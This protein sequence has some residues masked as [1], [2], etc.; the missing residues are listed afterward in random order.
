M[1]PIKM[2]IFGDVSNTD[3]T[4]FEFPTIT[5]DESPQEMLD[6]MVLVLSRHMSCEAAFKGGYMLNQLLGAASRRTS[7][8]D[9]PIAY[10]GDY[11]GVK[12][13]LVQIAEEFIKYD[14]IASYK[15]KDTVEER[16]SGGIDMYAKN[17]TKIL[18][19]DVGL[20][21]ISYGLKHYDLGFTDVDGFSI[22]RMLADKMISITSRKRFRRTK[23][24]YDFYAITNFFD[25]D[26]QKLYSYIE[27]RGGAE[28]DNIPFDDIVLVEYEKAW[29]KLDLHSFSDDFVI[30][31]P[32]F[33]DVLNR[34]YEFAI[35]FKRGICDF[36]WEHKDGRRISI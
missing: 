5:G 16:K 8:V 6:Y 26:M 15:I 20:H 11:E 10:K 17:G 33:V 23:D 31:K 34:F 19:V 32:N 13:C 24:I 21:N 14:L 12:Q 9:F 4:E 18:G 7:D 3:N 22:E 27:L 1:R 29:N 2:D 25:V 36:R 28:W 35:P 30:D